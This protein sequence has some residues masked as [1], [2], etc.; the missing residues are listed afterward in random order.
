MSKNN[1]GV[2]QLAVHP[3]VNRTV[4]GS[5]PSSPTIKVASP[6][7]V[8][9]LGDEVELDPIR[10]DAADI[11]AIEKR[12]KKLFREEIYLPLIRELGL[13]KQALHNSREDFVQAIIS[14][15][16]YFDRGI[17]KGRFSASISKELRNIRAV[18]NAQQKG[19]KISFSRLPQEIKTAIGVSEDR[20]KKV[21]R[22]IDQRLGEML[23]E[24]ISDQLKTENIFDTSLWKLNRKLEGTLKGITVAPELTDAQRI[25]IA[26]EYT[27]DLK[28]FI[29]DWSEKEIVRLRKRIQEKGLSGFRYEG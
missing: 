4:G 28:R 18:W 10:A 9:K 2:A 13:P 17:F 20:F 25:I 26:E 21:V 22:R 11:D 29:K 24:N 15:K 14:G 7:I 1:W 5:R 12:I 3:A 23:P 16:I 19:Y 6:L 8:N 27:N